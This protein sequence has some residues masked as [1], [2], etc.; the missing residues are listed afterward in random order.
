MLDLAADEFL[1]FLPQRGNR[2]TRSAAKR[3]PLVDCPEKPDLLRAFPDI[4]ALTMAQN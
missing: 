3:N 1:H 2:R 4:D